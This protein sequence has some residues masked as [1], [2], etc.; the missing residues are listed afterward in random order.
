M[1]YVV[2]LYLS[3]DSLAPAQCCRNTPL[4]LIY[5]GDCQ[6]IILY[7]FFLGIKEVTTP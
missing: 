5:T 4:L 6:D 1:K 2:S 3:Q 7:T